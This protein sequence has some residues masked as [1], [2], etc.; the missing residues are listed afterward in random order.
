MRLEVRIRL[1]RE[2]DD[3]FKRRQSINLKILEN[4][5]YPIQMVY[6]TTLFERESVV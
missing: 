2:A 6:Q 4:R 5:V 1:D 3:Q